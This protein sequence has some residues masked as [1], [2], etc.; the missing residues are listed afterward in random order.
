[1][2]KEIFYYILIVVMFALMGNSNNTPEVFIE[3]IFKPIVG[4]GWIIHYAGS[5]VIVVIYNCLKQLNEIK[6]NYLIKTRFNRV[7]ATIVLINI[8]SVIWVY[9]I[10]F[11]KGFFNDLNSIY[12]DR[13]KTSVQFSK[14]EDEL[15]VNGRINVVNC[16]NYIQKFHIK[17]K[18]PSLAIDDIKEEY[19]LLEKEFK[20]NPKEEKNLVINEEIKSDVIN[21]Y[22]G[23]SSSA[24]EYI[25][26]N[27]KD[28][29]VFKGTLVQYHLN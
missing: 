17:I 6:E 28:E 24:F 4:N 27:N 13:D 16:S 10:Q 22:S 9:C 8:F 19:I 25:L 23:Y 29:V 12:L 18:V 2:Q 14:N 1:M 7:I 11:Y 3:K 5:I 26:F 20:V 15:S 21:Q